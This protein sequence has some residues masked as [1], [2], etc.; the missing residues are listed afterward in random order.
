MSDSAASSNE[1]QWPFQ[2]GG[3]EA[4]AMVICFAVS[5]LANSAGVGG[6][7]IYNP[8]MSAMLGFSVQ[9]AA[10][11]SQTIIFLGSLATPVADLEMALLAAPTLLLGVSVGVLGNAVLPSWLTTFLLILLLVL[12][13]IKTL[14]SGVRMWRKKR[15]AAAAAARQQGR[16]AGA[17]AEE[18]EEDSQRDCPAGQG[19]G[20]GADSQASAGAL[21]VAPAPTLCHK[22]GAEVGAGGVAGEAAKPSAPAPP[23]GLQSQLA[24]P[25]SDQL[26]LCIK[27]RL[28]TS[29]DASADAVLLA[30]GSGGA[31]ESNAP[32]LPV[33]HGP[34]P[35][36]PALVQR[37][38]N[39][40]ASGW[41]EA[42]VA[43][44]EALQL[45]AL[46]RSTHAGSASGEGGIGRPSSP[47]GR[48]TTG[49]EVDSSAYVY[50]SSSRWLAAAEGV[51]LPSARTP[52]ASPPAFLAIELG[53][54]PAAGGKP[55]PPDGGDGGLHTPQRGPRRRRAAAA[56]AA[57]R[58]CGGGRFPHIPAKPLAML[59]AVTAVYIGIQLT[60]V[61]L[62]RC[63]PA[64]QALWAVQAVVFGGCAALLVWRAT[65][66]SACKRAAAAGVGGGRPEQQVQGERRGGGASSG[67]GQAEAELYTADMSRWTTGRLAAVSCIFLVGG[68]I[69]GL[70][71]VGGGIVAVPLLLQLGLHPQAAAATS[72]VLVLMS[73]LTGSLSYLVY[74][75][76]YG[77]TAFV[78]GL[79]GVLVVSML[80]RRSGHPSIV[81]LVLAVVI[82]AGAAMSAAVDGRQAVQDLAAALLNAPHCCR[83]A[84]SVACRFRLHILDHAHFTLLPG[85]CLPP[86]ADAL[87]A[88]PAA[89]PC[90]SG[91][92]SPA[93]AS[94]L[95][96]PAAPRGT[97][98]FIPNYAAAQ[99]CSQQRI[100]MTASRAASTPAPV[101]DA[102][103]PRAAAPL[104]RLPDSIW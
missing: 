74:A 65:C 90:A 17:A 56:R 26:E 13:C 8:V 6:G 9:M 83:G 84:D 14:L 28:T 43:V 47:S 48:S 42:G 32:Q 60:K 19:P 5:V 39:G 71:G 103:A 95:Q 12:I 97:G 15:A 25:D 77:A 50:A 76:V 64:W 52:L 34:Q 101:A 49:L 27:A 66:R 36:A 4:G 70:F 40:S 18:A 78:G 24:A 21:P 79:L 3:V 10:G 89:S 16:H 11:L 87:P 80:V 46:G 45:L 73:C 51:A 35:G 61:K 81:V 94:P 104:P 86:Y 31:P 2:L 85:A 41:Q 37:S 57:R 55:E 29:A 93:C 58:A 96:A 69:A 59:T 72:S 7:V 99:E 67:D 62:G 22:A 38:G 63:T 44:V 23:A 30:N 20:P 75:G 100:P 1:A 91:A 53:H 54:A 33:A 68:I 102:R 88:W 92:A 98:V 82:A